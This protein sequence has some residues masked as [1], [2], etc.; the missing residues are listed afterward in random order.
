MFFR[1]VWSGKKYFKQKRTGEELRKCFL[2][3]GT[4]EDEPIIKPKLEYF[5]K[6]ID[7]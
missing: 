4:I 6:E 5:Y 7:L 3:C 2:Y 1:S